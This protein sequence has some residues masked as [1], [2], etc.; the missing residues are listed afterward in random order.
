LHLFF[1]KP[2]SEFYQENGVSQKARQLAARHLQLWTDPPLR[3]IELQKMRASKAEWD[4]M[5]RTFLA[6]LLVNM[7]L[8]E[9]GMKEE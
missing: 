2:L 4:F 1:R 5:G 7:G 6:W 3:Q 8:R 9:P